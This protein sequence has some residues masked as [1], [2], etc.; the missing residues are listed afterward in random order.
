[1]APVEFQTRIEYLEDSQSIAGNERYRLFTGAWQKI[2]DTPPF[3]KGRKI[4]HIHIDVY[5]IPEQTVSDSIDSINFDA[6]CP[7]RR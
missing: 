7:V 3:E 4:K 1:M 6:I 5:G 2:V